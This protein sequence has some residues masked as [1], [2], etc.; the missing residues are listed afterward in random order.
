[1]IGAAKA[2]V[3]ASDIRSAEHLSH[4]GGQGCVVG[5][6]KI[7]GAVGADLARGGD[8][9]GDD[10][11]AEGHRLKRRDAEAFVETGKDRKS[12]V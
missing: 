3:A 2:G 6:V 1:M 7:E 5:R 12:V 10:R 4:M 11:T 9:G 8:V